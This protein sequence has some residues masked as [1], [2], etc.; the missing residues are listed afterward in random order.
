[1]RRQQAV[2]FIALLLLTFTSVVGARLLGSSTAIAHAKTQL[3]ISAASS[4]TDALKEVAPLYEQSHANVT[5]RYNFASSG[6]LQ[7]QI[8]QGAPTDVFISAGT[9]QMNALEQA[10]LLVPNS[11]QDLLTNRLV[12]I[13]PANQSDVKNTKSLTEGQV[14]RIAI[15]NPRSVPVGQYAQE[16][17]TNAG[18]WNQLQSKYVLATNVRQVLQFV[19]AGNSEAG[20]VYLTDAKMTNKVKI[21]Q[22]VPANLHSP[23]VYPIAVLNNSQ[24]QAASREFVEFLSG[25]TAKPVFAKYGFQMLSTNS[26][27]LGYR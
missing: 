27:K 15:G 8:E 18:V 5:I 17:L 12:L 25:P 1:M 9:K 19:A 20:L 16:A 22:I 23:I 24:N 11:R 7:Q 13:V 21:A 4:L 6:A 26:S 2:T 14:K 10:N 3:T